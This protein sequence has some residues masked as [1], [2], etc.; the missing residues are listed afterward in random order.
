[1]SGQ[2]HFV[3]PTNRWI[4][5]I[6]L[7]TLDPL[8]LEPLSTYVRQDKHQHSKSSL[9]DD[10]NASKEADTEKTPS[11][12]DEKFEERTTN[13]SGQP[14]SL[15][16][17]RLQTTSQGCSCGCTV[18]APPKHSDY[19]HAQHLLR[20][21]FQTQRVRSRTL[22]AHF[23]QYFES[24]TNTS[25]DHKLQH[26]QHQQRQ[27]S[28]PSDASDVVI[29]I[30]NLSY[31]QQHPTQATAA[32][33]N[34]H[35]SSLQKSKVPRYVQSL[36]QNR[37]FKNPLTNT[38]I[39][40][41]PTFFAVLEPGCGGWWYE[42]WAMAS[43]PAHLQGRSFHLGHTTQPCP[44]SRDESISTAQETVDSASMEKTPEMIQYEKELRKEKWR[45]GRIANL[46][47]EAQHE[48]D[49][50]RWQRSLDTSAD[51]LKPQRV[52]KMR[53]RLG[54]DVALLE[55]AE[56]SLRLPKRLRRPNGNKKD[57]LDQA[58]GMTGPVVTNML[59]ASG[60]CQPAQTSAV[61]R[62]QELTGIQSQSGDRHA[63]NEKEKTEMLEKSRRRFDGILY[64][65]PLPTAMPWWDPNPQPFKM[66]ET[67]LSPFAVSTLPEPVARH[68]G[69]TSIY[70]PVPSSGIPAQ[71]SRQDPCA[72]QGERQS[73]GQS[74]EGKGEG[75]RQD[76]TVPNC[77]TDGC[78]W[79]PV[80]AGDRVAVLIGTSKDFLLFPSFQ[81]L[82]FRH[83]SQEDFDDH[84]CRVGAPLC[85][86]STVAIEGR[87]AQDG[88]RREDGSTED[89]HGNMDDRRQSI[90]SEATQTS[91]RDEY[92][93]QITT[94]N[95]SRDQETRSWMSWI[96]RRRSVNNEESTSAI[97]SRVQE[98]SAWDDI[99]TQSI[100]RTGSGCSVSIDISTEDAAVDIAIAAATAETDVKELPQTELP[101]NDEEK[102]SA[103]DAQ[104]RWD[105]YLETLDREDYDSSDYSYSS[106]D[107]GEGDTDMDMDDPRYEFSDS[108]SSEDDR[109]DDRDESSSRTRQCSRSLSRWICAVFCCNRITPVSESRRAR[110]RRLRRERWIRVQQQQ[111]EQEAQML[112]QHLPGPIRRV[113][114]PA[115]MHRCCQVAEFCRFYI[116]ILMAV[117]LMG[118]IV[119]GAV[120]VEQ[121]QTRK[122]VRQIQKEP[123]LSP[124][125]MPC[126][127]HYRPRHRHHAPQQPLL[128]MEHSV[129]MA[130]ESVPSPTAIAI[131]PPKIFSLRSLDHDRSSRQEEIQ[132]KD[133]VA[134]KH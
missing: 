58:V 107:E 71:E 93:Q 75:A 96:A 19:Y 56:R 109:D 4:G 103:E 9:G 70:A 83:L 119:Y 1:M 37:S 54:K 5:S 98:S 66:P 32:Y 48:L 21:I 95:T 125:P 114:R 55:P 74:T 129:A 126:H 104:Q 131:G 25:A 127:H 20:L 41:D 26:P 64:E 53:F 40:G 63:Y 130:P 44:H 24:L 42:P 29:P 67:G 7:S 112:H 27:T 89:D 50:R 124:R 72:H 38:E 78:E 11:N 59:S 12:E 23:P 6:P 35:S 116:T 79:V 132:A 68:F 49:W 22:M 57:N 60:I 115:Q 94:G 92:G 80:Q 91:N 31:Q 2:I 118:A 28:A 110:R 133:Q 86:V 3:T 111:R 34:H 123:M 82:L 18:P 15:I 84:V 108:S 65:E 134:V 45:R 39:E 36:V 13:I 73:Q 43:R 76:E 106:S 113:I 99:Q 117:V 121:A 81:R 97:G 122:A 10:M 69:G 100:S 101:R 46:E 8:T 30:N 90:A 105:L 120:H 47:L 62:E 52:R 77:D 16:L 88:G 51:R 128:L 85:P 61:A 87:R 14:V 102:M 33:N 17:A